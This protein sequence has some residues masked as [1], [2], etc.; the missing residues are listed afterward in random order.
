MVAGK[1][2]V[3][4]AEGIEGDGQSGDMAAD[5]RIHSGGILR[6]VRR[7]QGRSDGIYGIKTDTNEALGRGHGIVAVDRWKGREGTNPKEEPLRGLLVRSRRFMKW[8]S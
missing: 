8:S 7:I 2:Q 6:V 4:L 3:D 1:C 5:F